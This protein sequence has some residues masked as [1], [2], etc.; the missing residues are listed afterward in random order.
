MYTDFWL[1]LSS[2]LEWRKKPKKSLIVKKNN[3][4]MWFPDGRLNLFDNCFRK[5]NKKKI[6]IYFFNKEKRLSKFSYLEL[7]KIIIN[8]IIQFKSKTRNIKKINR[9][10][11][12][13]SASIETA[14]AMLALGSLGIHFSVLFEDLPENAILKR[15]KIFKPEVFISRAA[16]SNFFDKKN[17]LK[18][19]KFNKSKLIFFSEINL[20]KNKKNKKI[21][22]KSLKSTNEFFTLF[23][24]GSTGVP[25]GVV[26]G[27]G[28]YLLYAKYT[29]I[30]K[31]GLKDNSIM[32]T[33]SD[34]GWINGHTYA[35]FGPLT[36]GCSTV[37]VER[38]IDLLD[39]KFL[40]KVLNI[41]V[42]VL[43]L[44]VTLIRLMKTIFPTNSFKTKYLNT[45]GSM[46]EPLAP[47]VGLWFAEKFND[48]NN[49]IVNTYFQT[50]T[51]GII[52][53]PSYSDKIIFSPHGSVGT[54]ANN[55]IK[56]SNLNKE[57]KEFKIRN[58]WP[59]CMIKL[60]N[61]KK[62]WDKYWDKKNYFRL[63]DFATKT[64]NY[65][66]IHGRVDDVINI[67]GHRIGSEE[68]ESTVL[69]IDLISEC[70]VISSPD[71]LAGNL[72]NLFVVKKSKK[73]K[74]LD[75][76]IYKIIKKNFGVYA[77]PKNIFY[78]DQLPKTKSGKILRRLLRNINDDKISGDIST[79]NDKNL[80]KKIKKTIKKN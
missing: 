62:E 60:L 55:N 12:H 22:F 64:K 21:E 47:N 3:S 18:N 71:E 39:V 76:K 33:A 67:R 38:P 80:I 44:P 15:I 49:A 14:A 53:S 45:L 17:F 77:L 16:R 6:A 28:G 34:A 50:E 42:S 79:I 78:L 61:G 46:G 74:S 23:T 11:I 58:S 57:K 70:A 51:G 40:K 13:G 54:L 19:K 52:S 2:K 29:C 7:E 30:K 31:F 32:L 73:I 66:N 8:F 75:N 24:S 72:I 68:I 10:I 63:F 27:L 41:G 43:Y 26:H 9:V 5:E 69:E 65:I 37:I 25:K 56:I 59:G 4:P 36:I 35:L 20:L 48:K 1:K